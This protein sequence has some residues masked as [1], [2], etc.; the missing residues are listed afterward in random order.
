MFFYSLNEFFHFLS[1][2]LCH[3]WNGRKW[4]VLF[5]CLGPRRRG[6]LTPPWEGNAAAGG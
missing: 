6:R 5:L 4:L 2:H 3:L 1:G